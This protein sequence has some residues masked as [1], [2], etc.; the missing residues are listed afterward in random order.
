MGQFNLTGASKVVEK[1]VRWLAEKE[2]IISFS[3]IPLQ[4]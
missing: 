2:D 1:W 4:Y 3:Y